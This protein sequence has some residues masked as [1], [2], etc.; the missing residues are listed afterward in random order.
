MWSLVFYFIHICFSVHEKYPPGK[1]NLGYPIFCLTSD[2]R[3][4]IVFF[5]HV[6]LIVKTERKKKNLNFFFLELNEEDAY[7]EPCQTTNMKHLEL[8]ALNYFR[9]SLYLICL[10]GL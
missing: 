1:S 2:T 8:L 7:L 6:L 3:K 4:I 5:H 9:K 10:T